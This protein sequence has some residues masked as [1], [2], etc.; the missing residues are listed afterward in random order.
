MIHGADEVIYTRRRT[1]ALMV[2][3]GGR[4]V[5]RAPLHTSDARINAL[6]REKAG[7]LDQAKKRMAAVPAPKVIHFENGERIWYQGHAYP[8]RL[9]KSV[10]GGLAFVP[11]KGFLLQE[12]RRS[13]GQ[14]LLEKFYR[15]ETRR[16]T[17]EVLQ[18]YAR[19]F[20]LHPTSVSVTAAKSRW[21]SCGA[22]N[23][24]NFSY[25]LAMVPPEALAYVVAHEL[26][27]T[28]H[29]NHSQAFWALV[30][31]LRPGFQKERALLRQ[32]GPTLPL[33]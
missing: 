6:L 15:A 10:R 18:V 28:V 20:D 11:A 16:L 14:R 7:W 12:D 3:P 2:Q 26:A 31:Q 30:A 27:H 32:H 22:R 23:T 19:R 4:V 8:L 21:G 25:R 1:L 24:I 29:H 17:G 33:L 13:E 9:E 5:V